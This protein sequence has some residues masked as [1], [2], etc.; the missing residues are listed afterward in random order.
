MFIKGF[1]KKAFEIPH[2]A[3]DQAGL[4]VL[5]V[6]PALHAYN[7]ATGRKPGKKEEIATGLGEVGGLAMLSRAA[8]KAHKGMA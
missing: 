6:A 8:Y 3:L 2:H 1:E 5:A 4:G 7:A